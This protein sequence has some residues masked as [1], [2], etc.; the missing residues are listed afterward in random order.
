MCLIFIIGLWVVYGYFGIRSNYFHWCQHLILYGNSC[1]FSPTPMRTNFISFCASADRIARTGI[2]SA[3]AG[4]SEAR[5]FCALVDHELKS[6]LCNF[7]FLYAQSSFVRILVNIIKTIMGNIQTVGPNEALIV[8]GGC[9][10]P[11]R[12]Q[13]IVGGWCWNTWMLTNIQRISLQVM[14]LSPK[15]EHVQSC[16][17]VPVTVTGVVHC[18]IMSTPEF[19]PLAAEQFLGKSIDHI[20]SVILHTVE[21]HMRAVI[22]TQTIEDICKKRQELASMIREATTKDLS[23][24]GI[25][26]MSLTIKEIKDDVEYLS[27]AGKRSTAMVKRDAAV[28]AAKAESE[29]AQ[30]EAKCDREKKERE[31]MMNSR[32]AEL[33]HKKEMA[34]A[35]QT[36]HVGRLKA[37]ATKSYDLQLACLQ[38]DIRTM[39]M[40]VK[41]LEF[42]GLIKIQ[43]IESKRHETEL[44]M[45][46]ELPTNTQVY[47]MKKQTEAFK[48]KQKCETEAEEFKIK[49]EGAAHAE[50]TKIEGMAEAEGMKKVAEARKEFNEAAILF[51]VLKVLPEIA[52]EIA[53]PL[54]KFEEI[55][56]ISDGPKTEK[57]SDKKY[58]TDAAKLS[59]SLPMAVKAVGG[60]DRLS[61]NIVNSILHLQKSAN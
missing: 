18:K 6:S 41:A 17:G 37:E 15:C 51:E 10:R 49:I 9:C 22:G 2:N 30:V 19:L 27:S 50:A 43:R 60:T 7:L 55:V 56:L 5:D 33:H 35:S 26:I 44:E 45:E 8:S 20:K 24:M 34:E 3:R 28:S 31:I 38:K 36:E 29:A 39:E 21:G 57:S 61:G 25:D 40:D 48:E 58:A 11:S 1:C 14:T 4:C 47:E 42:D 46:I 16:H 32:L 53:S 54:T 12:K 23:R 52:A 13:I 59:S